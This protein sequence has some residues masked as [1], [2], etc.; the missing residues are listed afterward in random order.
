MFEITKEYL[1][2]RKAYGKPLT[3]L[4]V[5]FLLRCSVI[6][7]RF[8]IPVIPTNLDGSTQVSRYEN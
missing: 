5:C 4:Q 7:Y 2:Q 6:F 3:N 8:L 1:M